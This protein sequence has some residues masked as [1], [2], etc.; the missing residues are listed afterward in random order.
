MNMLASKDDVLIKLTAANDAQISNGAS[1]NMIITASAGA[2]CSPA[3]NAAPISQQAVFG[4]CQDIVTLLRV[5]PKP[6]NVDASFGTDFS[7][8]KVSAS[9]ATGAAN[10]STLTVG[11]DAFSLKILVLKF[12]AQ[13]GLETTFGNNTGSNNGLR[14]I[15]GLSSAAVRFD[16]VQIFALPNPNNIRL[17]GELATASGG[18][19]GLAVA[20][21]VPGAI[22]KTLDIGGLVNNT[23]ARLIGDRTVI[24]GTMVRSRGSFDHCFMY[25]LNAASLQEVF[26]IYRF[27]PLSNVSSQC[28]ALT[29]I[30]GSDKFF[31]GGGQQGLVRTPVVAKFK[32][33]GELDKSFA[34]DG[35]ARLEGLGS[36]DLVTALLVQPNGKILAGLGEGTVVRLLSNGKYDDSFSGNGI[37]KLKPGSNGNSGFVRKL[38]LGASGS[39]FAKIGNSIAKLNSSGVLQTDFGSNG[40]LDLPGLNDINVVTGST[41]P[42]VQVLKGKEFRRIFQ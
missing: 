22:V 34:G 5:D 2:P 10:G 29:D 38:V 17:V 14:S 26:T 23:D 8:L 20:D 7:S 35:V 32:I 33:D 42:T 15:D 25:V 4:G 24:S 6:G 31:V 3:G 18:I 1:S 9:K 40:F 13:G 21:A 11:I 27:N 36:V 16:P 39:I 30:P 37:V 12:N 28:E 41:F 19:T